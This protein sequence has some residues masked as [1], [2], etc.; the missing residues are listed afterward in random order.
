[1]EWIFI[2]TN[3]EYIYKKSIKLAINEYIRDLLLFN[4]R[5]IFP[6]F[7]ALEIRRKPAKISGEK[8]APPEPVLGF[9]PE[10]KRDDGLL[11]AKVAQAEDINQDEAKERV[12]EFVD[13]IIFNF[14]KGERFHIEGVCTMFQDEDNTIRVAKDPSLN[15]DFDSFGL[16]TLEIEPLTEEEPGDLAPSEEP[17]S[18]N[19]SSGDE[20][21]PG[22]Q[23]E[24]QDEESPE[25]GMGRT[26]REAEEETEEEDAWVPDGAGIPPLDN[27]PEEYVREGHDGGGKSNKNTIW[28]LSGAIVVVLSALVIMTLKTD[29]LDGSFDLGSIFKSSDSTLQVDDDFSDLSDDDFEFDSMVDELENE[30]DSSTSIEHAMAPPAAEEKVAGS[31]PAGFNEYHII[32][33]SFRDKENALELQQK[34]TMAGYQSVILKRGDGYFRVS[35]AAFNDKQTALNTLDRFRKAKGMGSAWVMSLK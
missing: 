13:A 35:A 19:E 11:S 25:E 12:L 21:S 8:I 20:E 9:D 6:G 28:I 15:L 31:T 24:K 23:V 30:I 5:V 22:E 3:F 1:M 4:E 10:L 33:G 18:G 26:G 32:A 14:N 17:L 34:L 7:G 27:I 16:D 29:M 2:G